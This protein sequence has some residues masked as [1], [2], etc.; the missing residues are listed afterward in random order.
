M[1]VVMPL[2]AHPLRLNSFR[3]FLDPWLGQLHQ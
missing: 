2:G 1:K 3:N